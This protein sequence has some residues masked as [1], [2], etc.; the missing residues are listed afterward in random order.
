M[1]IE[2]NQWP[3]Y[4]LTRPVGEKDRTLLVHPKPAV[5][6]KAIKKDGDK[7]VI[8]EKGIKLKKFKTLNVEEKS[9]G[10]RNFLCRNLEGNYCCFGR[11]LNVK[12]EYTDIWP[13]ICKMDYP[14]IPKETVIDF[15][16]IWPGHPDSEVTTAIVECPEELKMRCFAVP[17]YKGHIQ[18]LDSSLSYTEGRL[19]LLELVGK[20]NCTNRYGTIENNFDLRKNLEKYLNYAQKNSLEGFVLKEESCKGWYKL[21]IAD[22]ADVFIMGFK[23]SNAETRK[24]MVTAVKV[25]VMKDNK[26]TY[27]GNVSGWNLV[28]MNLM[29]TAYNM[30]KITGK[31]SSYIHQVIKIQYQEMASQGGLRHAFRC[32][33]PFRD[34]KNWQSCNWEQF[35]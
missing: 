29:T 23:I 35:L 20:E 27:I 11:R 26:P 7:I 34:D 31:E 25:G 22:E 13:K 17:I 32:E 33:N 10:H 19:Q 2:N 1:S 16:L 28:E 24:G 21:K 8:D 4:L 3:M 12:N 5:D 6:R 15:E 9:A 30:M 14:E 18:I